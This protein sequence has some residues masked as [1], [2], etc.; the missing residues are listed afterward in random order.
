MDQ[1]D[2]N[3]SLDESTLTPAS[4]SQTLI[5][6]EEESNQST[7]TLNTSKFNRLRQKTIL[8]PIIITLILASVGLVYWLN[9]RDSNT[10]PLSASD[11]LPTVAPTSIPGESVLP[12]TPLAD[13]ISWLNTPQLVVPLN[14]AKPGLDPDYALFRWSEGRYY[15]VGTKKDGTQIINAYL[16]PVGPGEDYLLRLLKNPDGKVTV[17]IPPGEGSSWLQDNLTKE[18]LPEIK[19]TN[20][21]I[22]DLNPPETINFQDMKLKKNYFLGKMFS[23]YQSPTSLGDSS[24]GPLYRIDN[25]IEDNPSIKARQ[26]F[27]KLKDNTVIPYTLEVEIWTDDRLIA[28]NWQDPANGQLAFNQNFIGGCGYELF[29]TN[30]IVNFSESYADKVII[31]TTKSGKPVYKITNKTHGL[32]VDLYDI[33]YT[34]YNFEGNPNPVLSADDF[35]AE[36][37]HLIWQDPIGDWQVFINEQ[38]APMVECAKPVIYLYPEEDAQVKVAV[39]ADITLS[40]PVYPPGGWQVLA[41]PNGQLTY[42]GKTYGSL[43]WDGTGHGYYPDYHDQGVVVTQSRLIPTIKQQLKQ[44]GLND[45]E[46]ADF[47]EFWQDKLPSEPYVR[48]TWLGTHDMNLLAPLAVTPKPDTMIRIFL[49]FEG[50]KQFKTLKPQNL[51]APLRKGFTLVEW[52]GLLYKPAN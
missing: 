13:E 44:L 51:S 1:N 37:N 42:Q 22:A 52:G 43:F 14:L 25:L 29:A 40:D 12:T 10:E 46:A 11:S 45:R 24:F 3:T 26:I 8:I 49:E 6:V 15:H 50:L 21:V 48:L 34:F 31:G 9:T 38:Y 20:S 5:S 19:T 39:A 47:M 18:L 41:K 28:V 2:P 36:L 7:P 23:D 16:P 33:Y 17:I 35:S 32:V 30:P 27:L 4:P